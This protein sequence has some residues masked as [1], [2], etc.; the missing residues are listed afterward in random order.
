MRRALGILLILA[1]FGGLFTAQAM[2]SGWLVALA[3]FGAAA[4]L[5]AVI[6]LAAWLIVFDK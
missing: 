2:K 3:T 4:A 5:T 1:V 6:A